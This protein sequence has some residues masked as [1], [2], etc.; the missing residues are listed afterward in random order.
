MNE[1]TTIDHSYSV[2][3]CVGI[4][5]NQHMFLQRKT[6]RDL[7]KTIGVSAPGASRRIVGETEWT[8]EDLILAA[9]WLNLEVSDLLPTRDSD[10]A[11]SP[12]EVVLYKKK[13]PTLSGQA[14]ELVGAVPQVGLEP[15]TDGL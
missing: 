10:G 9:H 1:R 6:K 13:R 12:A 7:A 8:A 3:E 11:W 15:T 5:V 14:R 4:T 2:A